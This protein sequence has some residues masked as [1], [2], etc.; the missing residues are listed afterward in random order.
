MLIAIIGAG[1]VGQAL[2]AVWAKKNH[3]ITFGVRDPDSDKTKTA[4]KAAA[5]GKADS[6]S[7]AARNSEV[8]LLAVPFDAAREVLAEAGTLTGKA[9]L[10]ATNPLAKDLSGLTIGHDTSAGEQIA[11]WASG[12]KVVKIFNTTG[13]NNMANPRYQNEPIPML[14][15]GDDAGAKAIAAQL[16]KDAG[17]E[18]IDAGP[19]RNSRLLEPYA[20]LWIYL[21]YAGGLGREFAFTLA[22]R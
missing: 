2:G 21:A 1:S 19:L 6:I 9:I 15:A 4:L 16:A 18:P 3:Q 8:I 11:G 20:L 7:N 13:A 22:R 10:D 12:A 5:G 17:M 14:Y